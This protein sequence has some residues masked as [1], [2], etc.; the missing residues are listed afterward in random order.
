MV[1]HVEGVLEVVLGSLHDQLGDSPADAWRCEDRE[2]L[3]LLSY[4]NSNSAL[5]K[6]SDF[7]HDDHGATRQETE[8]LIEPDENILVNEY[9]G[10]VGSR[11]LSYKKVK[12]A[13]WFHHCFDRELSTRAEKVNID[14]WN[15]DIG[16]L[17]CCRR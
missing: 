16:F 7:D 14:W 15:T 3:N 5:D 11:A 2:H 12:D 6:R 17:P 8:S 10:Q 13:Q 4:Y 1:D 9:E